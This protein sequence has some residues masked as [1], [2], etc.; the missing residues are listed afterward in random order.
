MGQVIDLA[1]YRS[2]KACDA[3]IQGIR[4]QNMELFLK[5]M[6][7]L[8]KDADALSAEADRIYAKRQQEAACQ[9]PAST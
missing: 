8:A 5:G 4:Q 1:T 2:E 7:Q 6:D 3:A 9:T